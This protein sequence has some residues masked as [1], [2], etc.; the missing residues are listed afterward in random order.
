MNWTENLL[1]TPTWPEIAFQ[2]F[3]GLMPMILAVLNATLFADQTATHV[4]RLMTVGLAVVGGLAIGS[5][6][7]MIRHRAAMRHIRAINPAT[8]A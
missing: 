3:V 4:D 7:G 2:F 5:G 8:P 1:R 6:L